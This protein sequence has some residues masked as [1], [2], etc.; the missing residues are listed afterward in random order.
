MILTKNEI[1]NLLS[2]GD[3][4]IK[5]FSEKIL[6]DA[7]INLH[8]GRNYAIIK[9]SDNLLD[10]SSID[11]LSKNKELIGKF[12]KISEGDSYIIN[13]RQSILIESVEYLKIPKNI[14]GFIE[15]RS[16]FSRL[17]LSTP[18]TTVAPGFRGKIIFHLIG[19]TF[20]IKLGKNVSVFK[21]TL[22]RTTSETDG[23]NGV[24]QNQNKMILPRFN[25][26][27]LG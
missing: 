5:P 1:L 18:P 14:K 27:I 16:T 3:L 20:P 9:N 10:L 24:Y 23:Y 15:L 4:E 17:G 21:L 25:N 11:S 2:V 22:V 8:L 7:E 6:E 26:Y 19:S 12:Y 13:P